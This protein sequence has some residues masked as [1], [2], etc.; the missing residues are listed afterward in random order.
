MKYPEPKLQSGN[1]APW[2][3]IGLPVCGLST[4]PL[5]EPEV[6]EML[7]LNLLPPSTSVTL[8]FRSSLMALVQGE[9]R[10]PPTKIASPFP[11]VQS[12]ARPEGLCQE[13]PRAST[14]FV[15]PP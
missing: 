11:P 8:L 14:W 6:G 5:K 4:L 7:S 10:P 12:R 3:V 9:L 1:R 13:V 15:K 2:K